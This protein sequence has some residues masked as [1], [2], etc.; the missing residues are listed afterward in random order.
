MHTIVDVRSRI[1]P[2]PRNP[3]L[4]VIV[5]TEDGSTGTGECWWG[6][7]RPDQPPGSTVRPIASM[8]DD[9][10]AP[11][12]IGRDV[13]GI[14][15][16]WR[17]LYG[18][19][20]GYGDEGIVLSAISGIDLALWDLAGKRLGVPVVELLGGAV[21]DAVP[22]Y[23]SL[24]WLGSVERVLVD[25]RRALDAGFVAIKLHEADPEIA[26]AAR[27]ELGN[28]VQLFVDANAHYTVPG[29][30]R[31]AARLAVA[32]VGWLEEPTWPP[33][34]HGSL[35]RL[36]ARSPVPLAA[37]ENEANLDSFHRLLG[38]GAIEYLQP[39]ITR[40]GGLSAA[41][42]VGA[43]AEVHGVALCPHN[44]SMG[45]SHFAS[46]HWA[47]AAPAAEW[48]EVPWLSE[49]AGFPTGWVLPALENGA[50]PAPVEPGLGLP[51]FE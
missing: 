21:R 41:R 48:L 38:S 9:V 28:D 2:D 17:E 20:Y 33:H 24:D 30:I 8:V 35:V 39:E 6:A 47:A 5:A 40:I 42:R 26:V 3:V 45:P 32:G 29:A 50:I 36:A 19:A 27:V 10:L 14:E 37:G 15:L 12:C 34:D 13:R 7:Y 31:A 22:V 16:L 51:S 49:G 46:L 11:A 23:A 25:C 18:L 4:L 43:L 1:L 44:F